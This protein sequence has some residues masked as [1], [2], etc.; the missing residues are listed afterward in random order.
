MSYLVC[1][2]L[3]QPEQ[4]KNRL[5]WYVAAD[6]SGKVPTYF[7]GSPLCVDNGRVYI[8]MS[9]V[10][11]QRLSTSIVCYDGLGR[12]RW[13][14][15]VCVCPLGSGPEFEKTGNDSSKRGRGQNLL[16]WAAGQ[17]VYASQT[18]AIASVGAWTG[19]PTRP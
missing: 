8:A 10:V 15:E 2:D 14:R 4:Q 3:T 16:T 19:H 5:L 9:K 12:Q 17:I 6:G 11:D 1:L 7:E 13:S 18:G